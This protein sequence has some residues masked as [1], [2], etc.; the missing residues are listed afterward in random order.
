MFLL[1]ERR[2]GASP[3]S[4]VPGPSRDVAN[5]LDLRCRPDT[6]HG[7]IGAERADHP[8]ALE[9]RRPDKCRDLPTEQGRAVRVVQARVCLNIVDHDSLASP[10]GF[11]QLITQLDAW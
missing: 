10:D 7:V 5:K 2:F 8:P 11:A 1:A 6:R 4:R 9:H 3:L